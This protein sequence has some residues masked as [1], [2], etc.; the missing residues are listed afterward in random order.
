MW[1][2]GATCGL[3]EAD[4]PQTPKESLEAV[5]RA[6]AY[7]DSL[8]RKASG[9]G[10]FG[11]I[12]VTSHT[13]GD[14][15]K[16]EPKRPSPP[17]PSDG[18]VISEEFKSMEGPGGLFSMC[19][20]CPANTTRNEIAGCCG[21]LC[22]WPDSSETE[23][24]IRG[25]ISRLQL[26]QQMDEIFPRT[27]PLWY[28]L[29]ANSPVPPKAIGTLRAIISSMVEEDAREM[30]AANKIDGNQLRDFSLFAKATELAEER[31]IP[32]HVTLLPLGHTKVASI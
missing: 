20:A 8:R 10:I 19:G 23:E 18:F 26:E 3:R 12:Y 11:D 32:L 5:A 2:L 9:F 28:G 17:Y 21:T 1:A 25:I 30:K 27:E 13:F 22:Q 6:R 29:W 15:P 31:N 7:S 14:R 16:S 4:L 24:Q